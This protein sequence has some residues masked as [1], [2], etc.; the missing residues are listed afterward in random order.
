MPEGLSCLRV[1]LDAA[2]E[3]YQEVIPAEPA[4]RPSM[5]PRETSVPSAWTAKAEMLWLRPFSTYRNC[6][7]LLTLA[8][9]GPSPESPA[10]PSMRDRLPSVPTRYAETELLPAF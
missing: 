10:A 9:M 4:G 1:G 8:S 5:M 3:D 6:P 7:L 2:C